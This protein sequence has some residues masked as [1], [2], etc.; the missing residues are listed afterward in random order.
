M[1]SKPGDVVL[2]V[3]GPAGVAAFLLA[4]QH[5]SDDADITITVGEADDKSRMLFLAIDGVGAAMPLEAGPRFADALESGAEICG[6]GSDP[7]S[8]LKLSRTVRRVC[9]QAAA[10][11]GPRH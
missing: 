8:M 2:A 9:A 6:P 7:E 3:A 11:F 1:P 4:Y 10:L 5:A